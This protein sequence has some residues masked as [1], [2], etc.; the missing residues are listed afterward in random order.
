M[1]IVLV[2]INSKFIH[3]NPAIYSLAAYAGEYSNFITLCEFTINMPY[4]E[5]RE[6]LYSIINEKARTEDGD[7][8]ILMFSCY[9]WNISVVLDLVKDFNKL[10]P[11]ADI[12]LGGP[13][14]SWRAKNLL[15]EYGE[16]RGIFVGEGEES[17]KNTVR[18]YVSGRRDFENIRGI[19]FRDLEGERITDTGMSEAV[20]PDAVPFWYRDEKTRHLK[21]IFN[22]RILYYESQRGCPYSCSYCLSSIDKNVRFRSLE[23]V[24][25]DI[26][27]FLS[28]RV[29][30]VKFIDRTFNCNPGHALPIL[31][32]IRDHDNGI[33]N[34]HFEIEGDILN[35]D[36]I[37]LLQGLRPGLVQLEIGVQTTNTRTLEAV[38][39][40]NNIERLRENVA[41]LLKN[42]NIHIHLD[43]IAG[44]P[45]EN[46]KSF[47]DSFNEVYSM[48][49]H[50]LQ[51]GFLKVLHGA[52]IGENAE[53][54]GIIYSQTPPY[55]VLSTDWLTYSDILQLKKVERVLETYH[56]SMQFMTS[57]SYLESLYDKPYDM[58]LELAEYEGKT[59]YDRQSSSRLKKYELFYDFACEKAPEMKDIFAD[60][61]LY[62]LYLREN[63]KSLP[64]FATARK[65]F[66]SIKQSGDRNL[67]HAEHF[68]YPVSGDVIFDYA[69]R[70]PV[71]GNATVT[72][73]R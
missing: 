10:L 30:Q 29:K 17:F 39:R 11:K 19:V 63:I 71:T 15:D 68:E 54:Y 55:E 70:D 23:K 67:I 33:T 20:S 14:V 50:E 61:L 35:H 59:G 65:S 46:A 12:W 72:V 42:A 52:S 45:Y 3:S 53:K 49:P 27:F 51:L 32:F 48:H 25:E 41:E 40:R 38:N 66:K 21:E 28:E 9:I 56:N 69:H 37:R 34:F 13:E 26:G 36:E 43:L 47:E 64:N 73:C 1:E 8:K 18:A 5:I 31:E 2:G 4:E 6:E 58:Y 16:L 60:V 44:L 62:D 57:L 7:G 24:F 22:N